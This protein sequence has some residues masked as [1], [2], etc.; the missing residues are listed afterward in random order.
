MKNMNYRNA[1]EDKPKRS[2]L[3]HILIKLLKEKR[4]LK[5]AREKQRLTI[6]ILNEITN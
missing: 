1:K 2:T 5:A 3:R 6:G 4:M